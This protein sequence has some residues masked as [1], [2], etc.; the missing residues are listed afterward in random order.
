[1]RSITYSSLGLDQMPDASSDNVISFKW[2]TD[3]LSFLCC[4]WIGEISLRST[5]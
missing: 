5:I 4:I 2:F 3:F 1:M